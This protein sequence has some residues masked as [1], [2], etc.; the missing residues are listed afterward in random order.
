MRAERD[1]DDFQPLYTPRR[2]V[3]RRLAWEIALGIWVGGVALTLT[4]CGVWYLLAR[5]VWAGLTLG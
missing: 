4:G 3:E 1:E 2:R 5:G